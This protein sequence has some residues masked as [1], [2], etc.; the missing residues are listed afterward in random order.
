M[1]EKISISF[2]QLIEKIPVPIILIFCLSLLNP[3]EA[4]AQAKTAATP[5]QAPTPAQTVSRGTSAATPPD[6]S[7]NRNV[8][9][10]EAYKKREYLGE[11]INFKITP[12]EKRGRPGHVLVEVYNYSKTYLSVV[13]FWLI[14]KNSWGD[15]IEVHVTCDDI[16]P[17]WSALRW[18]KVETNKPLPAITH[19]EI[20]NM[21]IY[22]ENAQKINLRYYT[23]L[24]K[25]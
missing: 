16:K 2:S 18:V 23:D 1:T 21:V 8:I 5:K 25:L 9:H 4:K 15:L 19:V 7:V 17:S 14:L 20:K 3:T 6:Y 10:T 12:P 13:D 24:I 11:H 22:N